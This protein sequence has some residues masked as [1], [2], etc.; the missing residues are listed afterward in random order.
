[1]TIHHKIKENEIIRL[2]G[3]NFVKNNIDNFKIII[4]GNEIELK[5]EIMINNINIIN[6]IL[7]IKLKGIRNVNDMSYMF[8]DCSRYFKMEYK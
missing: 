6:N 8:Y 1:M 7:E 5:D 3:S 2:F 4:A